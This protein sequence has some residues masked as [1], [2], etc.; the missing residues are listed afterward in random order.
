MLDMKRNLFKLWN[1]NCNWN[2]LLTNRELNSN[3]MVT[4]ALL[5]CAVFAQNGN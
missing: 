5:E 2:K 3:I 1:W 4:K